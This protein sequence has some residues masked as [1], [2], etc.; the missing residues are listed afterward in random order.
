MHL[1]DS[2]AGGDGLLKRNDV[3]TA[4]ASEVV[5][6]C[7]VLHN[8]CEVHKEEYDPN[9]DQERAAEEAARGLH[10]PAPVQHDAQMNGNVSAAEIRDAL[11]SAL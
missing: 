3:D 2:R 9:W 6:V 5:A 4:F 10:Q 11:M 1:A 8:V 7:C